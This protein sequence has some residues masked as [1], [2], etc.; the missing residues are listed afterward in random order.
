MAG[1]R[2]YPCGWKQCLADPWLGVIIL[3]TN[4]VITVPIV[5]E[6]FRARRQN[7]HLIA[8]HSWGRANPPTPPQVLLPKP[9]KNY[10]SFKQRSIKFTNE[11]ENINAQSFLD[12]LVLLVMIF[13]FFLCL[14]CFGTYLFTNH[15]IYIP[16]RYNI[17]SI[18]TPIYRVYKICW[19]YL[20]PSGG[21]LSS[22]RADSL[23]ML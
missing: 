8:L 5:S 4:L 6:K 2:Q 10:L 23:I 18:K 20:F 13:F 1:D 17:Y 22:R 16:F 15:L 7:Q 11:N 14:T 3:C 9:A 12:V 21:N 19:I